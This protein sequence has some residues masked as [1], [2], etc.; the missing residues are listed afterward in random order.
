RGKDTLYIV[1]G[2]D[3]TSAF[4]KSIDGGLSYQYLGFQTDKFCSS[5]EIDPE[6]PDS[7]IYVANGRTLYQYNPA[8]DTAI[9]IYDGLP[10]EDLY[11]VAI[12]SILV[13]TTTGFYTINY[14]TYDDIITNV[15]QLIKHNS[16]L[17]IYPNP[18]SNDINIAY[19]K[20]SS[21]LTLSIFDIMGRSVFETVLHDDNSIFSLDVSFLQSGT[22]LI[23]LNHSTE[24]CLFIKK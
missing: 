4:I 23:Q 17:K 1:A 2:Y 19:D 5:L 21:T 20:T 7:V 8:L 3:S 9:R 6:N 11:D 16:T 22:Y 14:D 24:R 18:T 15:K 10:G 13:G 12:G